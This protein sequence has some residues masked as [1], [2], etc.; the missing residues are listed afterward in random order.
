[1]EWARKEQCIFT[2]EAPRLIVA[3][4]QLG[5]NAE[6]AQLVREL[7]TYL[8]Q[9]YAGTPLTAADELRKHGWALVRRKCWNVAEP[10]LREC[11]SIYEN[12]A[13]DRWEVYHAKSILGQVLLE[14]RK[15]ADA[16][17]LLLAAREGLRR[18]ES[19]IPRNSWSMRILREPVVTEL[20]TSEEDI[21]LTVLGQAVDGIVR[22]YELTSKP[23]KAMEWRAKR[24][25]QPGPKPR[26][27]E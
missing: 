8:K 4:V 5:R 13:A 23:E 6:A 26:I 27:V 9:K 7:T 21:R 17:S 24:P 20:E 19:D 10:I 22:V 3:S 12:E 15:F 2:D 11:L 1:V 25:P 16:E 14:Q 18:H